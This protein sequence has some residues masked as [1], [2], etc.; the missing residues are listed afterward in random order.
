MTPLHRSSLKKIPVEYTSPSLLASGCAQSLPA[1]CARMLGPSIFRQRKTSEH[2]QLQTMPHRRHAWRP[3]IVTC[4]V[5][6][7]RCAPVLD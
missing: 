2:R 6:R 5:C 3:T 1:R 7:S 4:V